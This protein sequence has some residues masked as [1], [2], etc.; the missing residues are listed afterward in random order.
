MGLS[1][2]VASAPFES[3]CGFVETVPRQG[4][5]FIADVQP[6]PGAP[7]LRKVEP[8]LE[9]DSA[10][11]QEI[12]FFT[13]S[14][15]VRIAYTIGGSGPPLVRTIDWLNHLDFEWK[16]PLRRCWFSEVMCRVPHSFAM[17]E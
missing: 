7:T 3:R 4:Y 11:E 15:G 2:L 12:Q 1:A 10:A 13:T 9:D 8:Y 6:V 17:F 5:R 16:N 14:D